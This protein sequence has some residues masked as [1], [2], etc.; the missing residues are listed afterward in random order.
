M[1]YKNKNPSANPKNS[2]YHGYGLSNIEQV[3][4]ELQGMMVIEK[5]DPDQFTVNISIPI[6]N[7][8]KRNYLT[9]K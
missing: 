2:L 8:A 5:D 1:L 7:P 4:D 9:L 6:I 3:V